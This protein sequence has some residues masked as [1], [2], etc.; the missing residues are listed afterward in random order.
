MCTLSVLCLDFVPHYTHISYGG[1]TNQN[2][3]ENSIFRLLYNW[4]K[5][6][7]DSHVHVTG[8]TLLLNAD[9]DKCL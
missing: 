2:Q 7:C 3:L 4:P 6:H 8:I 1:T 5:N 9:R